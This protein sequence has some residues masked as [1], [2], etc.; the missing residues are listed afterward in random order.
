MKKAQYFILGC[1]TIIIALS[2]SCNEEPAGILEF[3][4]D[5]FCDE[6]KP[7]VFFKFEVENEDV[8]I[9]K[10]TTVDLDMCDLSNEISSTHNFLVFCA[11][12]T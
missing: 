11:A 6:G 9:T 10:G 3:G 4:E 2:T 12:S 5:F 7:A 1:L 8:F